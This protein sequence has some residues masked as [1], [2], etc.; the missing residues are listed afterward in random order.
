MNDRISDSGNN[1]MQKYYQSGSS[2]VGTQRLFPWELSARLR[3]SA[4]V[5]RRTVEK[6]ER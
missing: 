3:Y 4:Q 6:F 2:V 1:I 5:I